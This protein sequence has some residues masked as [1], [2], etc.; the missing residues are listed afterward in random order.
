MKGF[1]LSALLL[2][3]SSGFSQQPQVYN[4]FFMNPYI[5]NPAYAGVE[6]HAA[7]FISYRD[8]W[9]NI[10]SAPQLSDLSFHVPLK[11]GIGLGAAAFN[12]SQGLLNTSAA[13]V[14]GSYL[15]NIDRTHFLRFGMS[16]GAGI[17]SV[18]LNELADGA[19]DPAIAGF[20][21]QST[22]FLGD[23]GV[24]YH[25]GHFNIGMALPNLF[26]YSPITQTEISNPE[27]SPT[28]NMLIKANYRGIL[29]TNLLLNHI[30]ST[31]T[32]MWCRISMRPFS[33]LIYTTWCG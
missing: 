31:D 4:Q 8:Q 5:Y 28:D 15:L 30:L 10:D 14:T 7:F 1:L 12:I 19:D 17:N 13:K 33:L 20:L 2:I 21:D 32:A 24:T 27:F 6:G 26:S 18:D 22:F 23:V 9:T 3:L 16:L 11:G 25:F 29:A